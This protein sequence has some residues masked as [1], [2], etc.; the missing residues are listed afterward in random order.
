[1]DTKTLKYQDENLHYYIYNIVAF[2]IMMNLFKPF[3]VTYL[4]ALGGGEFHI[5][6]LNSLPGLVAIFTII[7]GSLILNG[8]SNKQRATAIFTLVSRIA[9]LFF[10]VVP[11]VPTYI[12][13]LLFA[14]LVGI[15]HFPESLSVAGNQSFIADAFTPQKRTH[16][17]TI[18]RSYAMFIQII[19]VFLTGV[20]LTYLPKNQEQELWTYQA[21]FVLAFLVGVYEVYNFMKLKTMERQE[22][23]KA[24]SIKAYKKIFKIKENK[25]YW[26]FVLCSLIFH[27][28]WQMGWPLFSIKQVQ[29][30]GAD[31]LWLAFFFSASSIVSLFTY[32]LWNKWIARYGNNR[33]A[34]MATL[35][36]SLNALCVAIS[37]NLPVM[38]VLSTVSGIFTSGTVT[39]LLNL[40]LEVTPNEDRILYVGLY[41]TFINISLFISPFVGYFILNQSNVFIALLV[42]V[43][44]RAI[45]GLTFFIRYRYTEKLVNQ[46]TA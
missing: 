15:R 32:R 9:L 8:S 2:T 18:S 27:F 13:P 6:L 33:V 42:V 3:M 40:L 31:E 36:M 22:E 34:F 30:L 20:I 38:L 1:M 12:R 4:K 44:L 24:I 10:A 17:I 7:P 28:G 37:P 14:A 29:E 11:F 16:A 41:N 46:G 39:V 21:F 26:I 43:G 19:V 25:A 35:G 23:K 45:G 5:S